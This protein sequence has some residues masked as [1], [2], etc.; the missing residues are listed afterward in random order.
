MDEQGQKNERHVDIQTQTE[1]GPRTHEVSYKYHTQEPGASEIGITEVVFDTYSSAEDRA[2]PN[3][4]D[5]IANH[6]PVGVPFGNI[7]SF[8]PNGANETMQ[9]R[10]NRGVG[11]AVYEKIVDDAQRLGAQFLVCGSS[12]ESAQRFLQKKGFVLH[13]D[14]WLLKEL[15]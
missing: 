14:Y 9:Q 4:P 12:S 13:G 1:K 10:M 7:T 11:S 5:F 2:F 8:Y 15:S 6:I 3:I